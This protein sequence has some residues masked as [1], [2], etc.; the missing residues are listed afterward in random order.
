MLEIFIFAIFTAFMIMLCEIELEHLRKFWTSQRLAAKL[1]RVFYFLLLI[2]TII[3]CI[4]FMKR[5]G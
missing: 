1:Y 3:S 4:L 2:L 5:L